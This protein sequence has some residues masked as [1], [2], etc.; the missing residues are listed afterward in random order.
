MC[1][2]GFLTGTLT[3]RWENL[4]KPPTRNELRQAARSD[5]DDQWGYWRP[6]V[7]GVVK[8]T[9]REFDEA[10]PQYVLKLNVAMDKRHELEELAYQKA[11]GEQGQ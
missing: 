10:T 2:E 6:I 4:E 7:Y 5:V 1:S 3:L 9:Q 11:K 8:L